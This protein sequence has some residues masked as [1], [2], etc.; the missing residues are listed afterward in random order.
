MQFLLQFVTSYGAALLIGSIILTRGGSGTGTI[1][2]TYGL[3]GLPFGFLAGGL[4]RLLEGL[5]GWP[6]AVIAMAALLGAFHLLA[7]NKN[8]FWAGI[9][10]VLPFAVTFA[11][12]WSFISWRRTIV[13][14]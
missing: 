7:S 6:A 3:L 4:S 11:V 12:A 8:N 14:V 1:V 2:L 9:W 10:L 5:I 13:G